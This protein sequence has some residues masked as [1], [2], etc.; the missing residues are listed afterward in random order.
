M[1]DYWKGQKSVASSILILWLLGSV[2]INALISVLVYLIGVLLSFPSAQFAIVTLVLLFL[3]N[4]YYIFC[5]IS[6]WKSTIRE[7]KTAI[8]IGARAM[9]SLHVATVTYGVFKFGM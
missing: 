1:I 8:K 5:W 7:E 4:P 6:V 9:V 3:F 2:G